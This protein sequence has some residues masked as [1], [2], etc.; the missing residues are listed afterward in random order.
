MSGQ[1]VFLSRLALPVSWEALDEPPSSAD[2][3][4]AASANASVVGFLL[5]GADLDGIPRPSDEILAE[6]LAPLR[7]KLDMVLDMLGRLAYRDMSVP[8]VCDIE[9]GLRRMAWRSP[10]P[11]CAGDWLRIKVYFSPQFPE[12][13]VLYGQVESAISEDDAGTCGVQAEL[14]ETPPV[15]EEAF[16][17]L[18]F[19]AQRRQLGQRPTA[20]RSD[21]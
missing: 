10:R 19:L 18:A 12:P 5:H 2:R 20:P 1:P 7:I 16:A 11:L 21:R 15:A 4:M 13:V 14:T 17:R 6:A 9:L 8:P 3:E